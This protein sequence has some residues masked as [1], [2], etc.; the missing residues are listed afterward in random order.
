MQRATDRIRIALG[1]VVLICAVQAGATIPDWMRQASAQ[2][3]PAYPPDTDAVVLLD[4]I[5]LNIEGPG[6]Y[7]E[8][9]RRVV[10]ILRQEGAEYGDFGVYLQRDEKALSVHAWSVDAAKHEFEV[11]D[12]DFQEGSAWD[13]EL[14]TDNKYRH[15]KVPA[16]L[17]GTIVGFEYEAR[18]HDW[19]NLIPWIIQE[20]VPVRQ[21]RFAIYLPPGWEY[22]ST[23]TAFRAVEPVSAGGNGWQWTVADVAR[24]EDEPRRPSYAALRG[25]MSLAY[26]GPGQPNSASWKA[27]G[28]WYKGLTAE[29]RSATPEIA[30]KVR[31]LT[32]NAP[33]FES[34]LRALASFI[35]AEI[36]YVAI[37]IGIGGFQPHPAQ[38]V[39]RYRYGD[40]KDKVTLLSSMLKEAGIASHYV[41]I[42]T[43]RGSVDPAVPSPWFNHAI[44]AIEL[45]A[46]QIPASFQ[47]VVKTESGKHYLLFDPT[48]EY[49]PVGKIGGY[50]QNSHGLLVT[51]AGGE[52]VATPLLNPESN[53]L[54]R[55]GHFTLQSDG[56]ITGE[57][58]EERTGDHAADER[59]FLAHANDQQRRQRVERRLNYS[60][61][62]FTLSD[63]QVQQPKGADETLRLSLKLAAPQYAQVR[64]PLL[65]VR[66][67]VIGE[68]S[69]ALERKPR[70]YPLEFE[71]PTEEVDRFELN[72]P[73]GYLVDELPQ[74]Q[75]LDFGF[76]TY[77]S[78]F[79]QKGEKIEYWREYKQK[80]VRVPAEKIEELRKL[81]GLIGADEHAM[82]ILKHAE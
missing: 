42:S 27:I 53:T 16:A 61:K 67:R 40:C 66:P 39:F 17:P 59:R 70:H 13:F 58:V 2:G 82:V 78:K 4:D 60:L 76:A 46:G 33:D 25:R 56:T 24:L 37:E 7:V 9:Y 3:L 21:A 74:G 12:K 32:V 26:F 45:P 57:L 68:K 77:R 5:E 38:D 43:H 35:Q 18:R 28:D 65:L 11:K 52:L 69:F 19:L 54:A 36:R 23:W 29:R 49:T 15:T 1:A 8:H 72:L 6:V 62:G 31:Q 51:E 47:A 44:I 50:I 55:E 80:D 73:A 41:L 34:K 14:Y 48:D 30:D 20:R 64:G 10:K 63:L 79:E 81:E 22:K 71:T 75:N